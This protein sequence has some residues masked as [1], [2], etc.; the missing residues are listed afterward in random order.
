[1]F[2]S[3]YGGFSNLL[4]WFFQNSKQQICC[5][6]A[7]ALVLS[8]KRNTAKLREFAACFKCSKCLATLELSW[9]YLAII[10]IQLE[11]TQISART[12]G[13]WRNRKVVESMPLS[14]WISFVTVYF[15][16]V[17]V[18]ICGKELLDDQHSCAG[19]CWVATGL[20]RW[21]GCS[22]PQ[23][24]ARGRE[25][26]NPAKMKLRPGCHNPFAS[27]KLYKVFAVFFCIWMMVDVVLLGSNL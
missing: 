23:G 8:Y 26:I 11:K 21:M 12:P 16:L 4:S 24:P 14:S 13:H 20:S 25:S 7:L 5:W 2:P 19:G 22:D 15:Q 1:M 3:F 18:H 6:K 10:N 17:V 27:S 9:F